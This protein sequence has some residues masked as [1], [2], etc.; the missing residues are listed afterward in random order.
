MPDAFR[1]HESGLTSPAQDAEAVTPSD[2]APLAQVAR[3]LYVGSAGALRVRMLSGVDVT[4]A[5]VPAGT[6]LPLRA[7]HVLATGTTAGDIVALR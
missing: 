2:A 6:L 4:F 5:A 7:S 1:G 3:G